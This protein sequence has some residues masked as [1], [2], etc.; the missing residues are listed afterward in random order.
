MSRTNSPTKAK[1]YH[2]DGSGRDTYIGFNSGGNTVSF[3]PSAAAQSGGL[4][5][6][7]VGPNIARKARSPEKTTHY[8]LNGTGRD[9]YIFTN[10]GGFASN[11]RYVDD[12]KA[13]VRSL[14]NYEKEQTTTCSDVKPAPGKPDYF[15]QGQTSLRSPKARMEVSYVSTY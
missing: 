8:N 13:Y 1:L 15:V 9:T 6:N 5:G 12:Q 4:G 11:Y 14:R 2:Q 3:L 10:H 7:Y